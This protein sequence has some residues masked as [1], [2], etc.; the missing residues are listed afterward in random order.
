MSGDILWDA[1]LQWW[2]SKAIGSGKSMSNI[3]HTEEPTI[4]C[5]TAQEKAL[6]LAVAAKLR[7]SW[8]YDQAAE[9]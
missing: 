2:H 3:Q 7:L 9:K 8:L 5:E 4:G 1:A 6:A